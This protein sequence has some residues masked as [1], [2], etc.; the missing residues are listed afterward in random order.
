MKEQLEEI[1]I[2]PVKLVATMGDKT[3]NLPLTELRVLSLFLH[4]KGQVLSRATIHAAMQT[5]VDAVFSNI[6]DVYV[7]YLRQR[8]GKDR[9]TTVRGQG[10]VF[11]H[12]QPAQGA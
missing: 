4:N 12:V 11:G 5:T 3:L 8:I 7:N 2:D 1:K 10:Y 9:I 6:V